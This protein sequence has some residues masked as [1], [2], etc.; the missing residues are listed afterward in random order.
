MRESDCINLTAQNW[1]ADK[2]E[3]YGRTEKS[4]GEVKKNVLL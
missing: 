4:Y 1:L 3:E 2:L